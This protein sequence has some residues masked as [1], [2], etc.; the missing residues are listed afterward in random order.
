MKT[1]LEYLREAERNN[2]LVEIRYKPKG[3]RATKR[4]ISNIQ[5]VTFRR[6]SGYYITA[7]CHKVRDD[8]TFKVSRIQSIDGNWFIL[9]HLYNIGLTILDILKVIGVILFIAIQLLIFL[10]IAN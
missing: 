10:W 5:I 7:Y 3:K 6:R 2:I 9:E 8:R 1:R 4:T